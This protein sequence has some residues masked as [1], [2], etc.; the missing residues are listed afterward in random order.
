MAYRKPKIKTSSREG[1]QEIKDYL[2]SNGYTLKTNF[3]VLVILEK[4]CATGFSTKAVISRSALE[5]QQSL[6][7]GENIVSAIASIPWEKADE[8]KPVQA[9]N[10]LL[11]L[12][13]ADF[14]A[15]LKEQNK[16]AAVK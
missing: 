6:R 7:K 4:T 10:R 9:I 2:V 3:D 5:V 11:N 16:Q 13:R 14:F 12:C 1:R 15:K 8:M